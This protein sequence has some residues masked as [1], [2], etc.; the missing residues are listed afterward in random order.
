[1]RRSRP[2]IGSL[3]AYFPR[4][5]LLGILVLALGAFSSLSWLMYQQFRGLLIGQGVQLAEQFA[6]TG[7]SVFLVKD[8]SGIAE[9]A[10]VFRHFPGVRYLAVLDRRGSVRFETGAR[11]APGGVSAFVP[12]EARLAEELMGA[13]R[14]SAPIVTPGGITASPFTEHAGVQA[15]H[16]GQVLIEMDTARLR[17]LKYPAPCPQCR[18]VGGAERCSAALELEGLR[19]GPREVGLHGHHHPRDAHPFARGHR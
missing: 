10:A 12:P 5:A 19:G 18:G 9:T 13:W 4:P 3:S 17:S 2:G 7:L 14:F 1:V 11:S 15:E 16:I 8:L 6:Q